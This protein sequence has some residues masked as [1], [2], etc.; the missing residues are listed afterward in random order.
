M[1][2]AQSFGPH[3][4]L[5]PHKNEP[6]AWNTPFPR[7]RAHA[8]C[9][10]FRALYG[11]IS[12]CFRLSEC[13]FVLLSVRV[14]CPQACPSFQYF[15]LHRGG[16]KVLLLHK[17]SMYRPAA[18]CWLPGVGPAGHGDQHTNWSLSCSVSFLCKVKVLSHPGLHCVV[19]S[20][21]TAISRGNRQSCLTCVPHGWCNDDLRYPPRSCSPPLASELGQ[22]VLL[23]TPL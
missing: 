15:R 19:L 18:L 3:T 8:A 20:L 6:W 1:S 12:L 9:A 23:N 17:G 5:Q 10:R 14:S 7:D 16:V 21:Q 22:R 4:S 13:S 2:C 11:N